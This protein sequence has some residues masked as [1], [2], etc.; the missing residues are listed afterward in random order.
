MKNKNKPY[1]ITCT[2][3]SGIFSINSGTCSSIS[4][5]GTSNTAIGYSSFIG[6]NY[7]QSKTTYKILGKEFDLNTD[8]IFE[9]YLSLINFL[10]IEYYSV[11][12]NIIDK[13]LNNESKLYLNCL[14]RKEKI[15][16]I[17]TL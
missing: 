5:N 13:Y 12:S 10:G 11:N 6:Y 8:S 4:Y 16:K 2:N 17:K 14:I 1:S 15:K 7:V 3:S 9:I